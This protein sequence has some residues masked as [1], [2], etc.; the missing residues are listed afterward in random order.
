MQEIS[1]AEK[2]TRLEAILP[3]TMSLCDQIELKSEELKELVEKIEAAAVA[4]EEEEG[5]GESGD[6]DRIAETEIFVLE[7]VRS[8]LFSKNIIHSCRPLDML[9]V[10]TVVYSPRT[11][12]FFALVWFF[13][14]LVVRARGGSV[15]HQALL[16]L[17]LPPLPSTAVCT[18]LYCPEK[19]STLSFL[20]AS[21]L[22]ALPRHGLN[23]MAC[24][25]PGRKTDR[26]YTI[27][28]TRAGNRRR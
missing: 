18:L 16:L 15:T 8:F 10:P 24:G 23:L 28:S 27:V 7:Q 13:V 3:D 25:K 22:I 21:R 6:L 11:A 12:L 4:E 14:G 5:E 9:F 2:E 1:A 20:V 19:A 26:W 17:L